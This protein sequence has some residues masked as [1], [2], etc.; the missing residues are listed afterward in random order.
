VGLVVATGVEHEFPDQL[1][2]FGDHPDP[3]AVDQRDHPGAHELAAEP[4]VVQPGVVTMLVRTRSFTAIHRPEPSD[5]A[6]GLSFRVQ[7]SRVTVRIGVPLVA[8]LVLTSM[9]ACGW[10]RTP[11][12][13]E[14]VGDWNARAGR[15][16]RERVATGQLRSAMVSGWLAKESYPGCGIIFITELNE[17][18]PWLACTRTFAAAV[19]RQT[20][21]SCEAGDQPGL[22][23]S[24]G[25]DFH[26]NAM[27]ITGSELVW[28]DST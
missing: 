19:A 2:V 22:D 11:S 28:T 16:A 1:T 7:M 23:R 9:A 26:A 15:L 13:Q 25:P 17:N 21:W 4:D 8:A 12:S 6:S 3:Q 24:L 27:V 20:E 5:Q 14:C 18:E 10:M